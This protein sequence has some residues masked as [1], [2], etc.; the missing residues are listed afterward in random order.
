MMKQFFRKTMKNIA[1]YVEL[2]LSA[3][4]VF[5][6]AILIIKLVGQCFFDIWHDK[7][8]LEYYME[9]AMSL[10]IGVEFV[11][12]LCT[13]QPGTIIE[14]LLFATARQMIVE[15]LN[16]YETLVGIGAIAALFTIRKFLFCSFDEADHMICRGSQTVAHANLITGAKIPEEKTRILRNVISDKLSEEGKTVAIG[17]CVYYKDCALRVDS[18]REGMVT[19]TAMESIIKLLIIVE[20]D[21]GEKQRLYISQSIK[22]GIA[23]SNKKSGR[24]PGQLDKMSDALRED[25]L[26]Y[27]S[28]RSIK[29][30]DLM[31]KYNISR[32]TLKKYVYKIQNHNII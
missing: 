24:K 30:V 2:V 6:I 12:M 28:D 11:K 19:K 32:N 21:R 1:T 9:Y 22:D 13:H 27:L 18:M 14:V 23:A 29:Q 17:A 8:E 15:H 16:V 4:L 5:V 7:L 20:L 31:R 3:F 25:I 10:A 26:K